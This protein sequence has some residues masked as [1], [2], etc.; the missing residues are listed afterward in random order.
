[1]QTISKHSRKPIPRKLQVFVFRRDMWLCHC[2][3]RP[4]IFAPAMKYRQQELADSGYGDL[5]YWRYAFDR[6]GAPLLD[7]LA[8]A[9]DHIKA[10]TMGG[11]N[12][13]ENLAPHVTSAT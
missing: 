11:T 5:A 4:V 3:K 7:E 9:I 12:D 6:Q 10:F 13:V 8:A 2:C 1:M